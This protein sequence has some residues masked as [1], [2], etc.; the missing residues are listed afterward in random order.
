MKNN[1]ICVPV[2]YS[3]RTFEVRQPEMVFHDK[4]TIARNPMAKVDY[5]I[6][7]IMREIDGK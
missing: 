1:M 5:D 6:E 2:N 3:I 7:S 4:N